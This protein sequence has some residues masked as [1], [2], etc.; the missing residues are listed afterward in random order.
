MKTFIFMACIIGLLLSC[1]ASD[2]KIEFKKNE[3]KM[4]EEEVSKIFPPE[5][6]E[7]TEKKYQQIQ[8]EISV[9]LKSDKT[10]AEKKKIIQG[11]VKVGQKANDI[12]LRIGYYQAMDGYGPGFQIWFFYS[13]L[14]LTIYPDGTC[15]NIGFNFR[16]KGAKETKFFLLEG[17]DE[18][19]WP[20]QDNASKKSDKTA[21]EPKPDSNNP[22]P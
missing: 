12:V 15:A 3:E 22:K 7:K 1:K 21:Q 2:K 10:L 20:K 6:D 17:P 19:S 4:T 5:L 14:I 9:I 11:F 18:L 8:E 13:G 16:P